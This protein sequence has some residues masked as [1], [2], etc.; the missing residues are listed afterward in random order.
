ME[1]LVGVLFDKFAILNTRGKFLCCKAFVRVL[2][3]LSSKGAVLRSF[4][5]EIG[6]CMRICTEVIKRTVFRLFH[7]SLS[8]LCSDGGWYL[9]FHTLSDH[10]QN[11][12]SL[13]CDSNVHCI[14]HLS[15]K[16]DFTFHFLQFTK[17]SSELVHIQLFWTRF[18][19]SVN[20]KL[21]YSG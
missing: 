9:E 15:F 1:R 19:R 11:N 4:L 16:D 2:F 7:L 6:M 5:S 21:F 17:V 8:A 18:V 3:H 20:D 12:F 14:D 10:Q 13:M